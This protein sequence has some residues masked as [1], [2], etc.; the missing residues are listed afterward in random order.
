MNNKFLFLI[1]H[2]D[3]NDW[4][5]LYLDVVSQTLFKI[6]QYGTEIYIVNI[7]HLMLVFW[8]KIIVSRFDLT[9]SHDSQ[10]LSQ[11]QICTL[12]NI[13]FF[14]HFTYD[15]FSH[16]Y[17]KVF[18]KYAICRHNY[19]LCVFIKSWWPLT[20][21]PLQLKKKMKFRETQKN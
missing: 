8:S 2:I 5:Y 16:S 17:H 1:F 19:F 10:N 7:Y 13:T 14:S 21:A 6:N 4:W 9:L 15:Y 20:L 18:L 12:A 3:M 11:S